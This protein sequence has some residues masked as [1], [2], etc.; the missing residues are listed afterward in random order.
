MCKDAM[1]L[2]I[3]LAVGKLG[4]QTL[5]A[6]R[7]GVTRQA[8]AQWSR[9]PA[10]HVLEMENIS[11]VSRYELRPDV[12]GPPPNQRDGHQRAFA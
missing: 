9:V 7:I 2:A 6:R 5:V 8:M 4:S 11:G 3:K 12:Y 1:R 10:E